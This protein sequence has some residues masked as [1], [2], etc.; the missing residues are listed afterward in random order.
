M[1]RTGAYHHGDLRAALIATAIDLIEEHGVRSFSLAAA[2]R[3]L[4]VAVSAP[5]A[6]FA[7]REELLVA[8]GVHA[9]ELFAAELLPEVDRGRPPAERLAVMA[10]AY[11]RFA[12]LH[13]ALFE[14]RIEAGLDGTRHE[15]LRAAEAPIGEAFE[16]CVG[17]LSDDVHSATVLATALEATVQG[18]AMFLLHGEFGEGP[19]AI[20][21]AAERAVLAVAAL[22]E[23]RHVLRAAAGP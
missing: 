14:V 1:T 17:A 19:A 12:G 16:E 8:I 4:G 10:R 6:H 23:G 13:R 3:R 20:E 9:Y 15:E 5:Y 11:V 22:L 21:V 18:H 7:D 2:S